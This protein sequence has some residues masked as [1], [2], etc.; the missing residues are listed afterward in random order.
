MRITASA[1]PW[2]RAGIGLLQGLALC[3]LDQAFQQHAWP[4]TDGLLF[5]PLFTLAIFLPL[6]VISGLGNLRWRTLVPWVAVATVV[7]AGLAA[8]DVYRDPYVAGSGF[9]QLVLPRDPNIARIFPSAVLWVSLAAILFMGHTLAVSGAAD[10]RL[11]ASYATHFDVSWK[12]GVQ[13][14]LAVLFVGVFWGTAVF[15]RRVVP[16]RP[17][18]ISCRLG[19]AQ[20]VLD[21][22]DYGGVQ[23][24]S[25][26]H[27]HARKYRAGRSHPHLDPAFMALAGDG[28]D[29]RGVHCGAHIHR[30][31]T[32]VE[33]APRPRAPFDPGAAAAVFDQCRLSG[34]PSGAS[35]RRSLRYASVLAAVVLL[36]LIALAAYGV[37]LRI[38]QYGLTPERRC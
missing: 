4:G 29:R 5:A 33:H 38:Q 22:G 11:V 6:L 32:A 17:Y 15:R 25:A 19:P 8:Y 34:R 20:S 2:V 24:R 12:H 27:R 14:V 10:R 31:R 26:R 21:S 13:S 36:V 37:V 18:R 23:L 3:A 7:C 9:V 35:R 28:G 1:M 30:A 16:S